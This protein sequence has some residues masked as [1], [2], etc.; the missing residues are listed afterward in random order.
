MSEE[1]QLLKL[2]LEWNEAYPRLDVT[3]LD[4]IIADDLVCI[5]GVGLII[6][7]KRLTGSPPAPV[8]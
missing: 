2:D 6:T 1:E 4:R 3:A 7:K 8:S 5:D